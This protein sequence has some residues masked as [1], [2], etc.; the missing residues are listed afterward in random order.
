MGGSLHRCVAPRA[1][2]SMTSL[3]FERR[4]SPRLSSWLWLICAA[5]ALV[6]S[7]RPFA[8]HV[9]YFGRIHPWAP[10]GLVAERRIADM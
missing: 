6:A 1:L 2:I 9:E 4:F 7:L 10:T 5:A 3:P 8:V